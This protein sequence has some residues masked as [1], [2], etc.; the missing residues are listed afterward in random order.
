M[1]TRRSNRLANLPAP[2]PVDNKQDA[3]TKAG[4]GEKRKAPTGKSE[5][6]TAPASKAAKR[7]K[8]TAGGKPT[9]SN[10]RAL[11][12]QN[13]FGPIGPKD[14]IS[15]LPP[16]IFTMIQDNILAPS[17]ISALG[18]TSKRF[19][20]LMMPKLYGRI[21]VAA[22]FHAHIPKLIRALEPLL[23]IGQKKQ[24]KKEGKYKG[25][26][27]RYQTGL[28]E[29]AKPIC[30]SYVRQFV[31]GVADPGK[32][33]KYICDRYIEEAFKN[34]KN[35][36]IVET[37]VLTESISH[38]I[39]SLKNLKALRLIAT[40]AAPGC[41]EPLASIKNLKHL[42]VE[43]HGYSSHGITF[44]QSMLR[45]SR[46]TLQSLSVNSHSY[47]LSRFLED[48]E[49]DTKTN[50]T[51]TSDRSHGF[52]VL[53]SFSLRGLTID[54]DFINELDKTIYFSQLRELSLEYL[55]DPHCL[56][57]NYLTKQA[58]FHQGTTSLSLRTL[59]L[60]MSARDYAHSPTQQDALFL[61]KCRFVAS[62][63]T[64]TS[65]ELQDYGQYPINTISNPGLSDAL[66]QAIL[67]HKK[68]NEL[69][70]NYRGVTSGYEVPYL[71]AK[72]V[73]ILVDSL[74]QLRELEF[75]PD[76]A[77]MD[78]IG[79]AL[80]RGS[81]LESVTCFPHAS[82]A[83]YPRPEQPGFDIISNILS[84]FLSN[85]QVSL[86][87]TNNKFVWED[88]YNLRR[89]SVSYKTW[90][91]ASTFEKRKRRGKQEMTPELMKVGGP[92]GTREVF[93]RQLANTWRI[94][95][96]YDPDFEWVAKHDKEL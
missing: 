27:E 58:I 88:H 78:A 76:E 30:A 39:A 92:D 19:Y 74:P 83:R 60:Y 3:L 89:V 71:N 28:D 63:D 10:G 17:A 1:T 46:T 84:A 81:N 55:K 24:L 8:V 53:K 48:C 25:Q 44:L 79:Q 51:G 37:R 49:K 96:G 33:H 12:I 64:L 50:I 14:K 68:L 52:T 40:N 90:E 65:L 69:R 95:V 80:R 15:S 26:Q 45:N 11:S 70:I 35:L 61:A 57:P 29:K 43:D 67:K 94:H 41:L 20:S 82:W 21:A 56:L 54:E 87:S 75:A 86:T 73:G 9:T 66:L 7:A 72:T 2:E 36:E 6:R 77:Q 22:M 91:I 59:S 18:R 16:E 5:S 42:E 32:K 85:P 31:A 13:E 93:Y 34:M 23:S 4:G 47:R 38:S 62:F